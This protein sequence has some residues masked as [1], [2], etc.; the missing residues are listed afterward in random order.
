MSTYTEEGYIIILKA[1]KGKPIVW[2][3]GFF[4]KKQVANREW[5]EYYQADWA[6]RNE[7]YELLPAKITFEIED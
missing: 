5:E 4:E 3:Q 1:P 6:N 2:K 7:R